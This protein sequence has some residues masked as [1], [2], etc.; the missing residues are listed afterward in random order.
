MSERGQG[1]RAKEGR[2]PPRG[3]ARP[4]SQSAH[5]TGKG[6]AKAEPYRPAPYP[7][8]IR[9]RAVQLYLEEGISAL[10]VARELG[11]SDGAVHAWAK[12][13]RRYGEA[14]LRKAPAV[15]QAGARLPAAVKE[16][17]TALKREEPRQ[18]ARRISQILRR[19]FFLK[20]SPE[21]VRRHLKATGL[22]TPKPKARKKPQRAARRFERSTPNQMWQSD[23]T[24]FPILGQ[25]AY[26][27]G[28]L[29]DY[30]RYMTGLGV[31]R[32]QP[33]AY[34]VEVY[35]GAVATYGAPKEMLT[36]N[37]RQYVSWRGRTQFQK[38][39]AKDHVHHIRSSAHHPTTLG[40]IERLWQTLKEEFLVRARFETFEEARERIG[41]WVK[42]YNHRRP[43]QG[44]EGMCPADRFFSIHQELRA[45]IERGVAAN[46]EELALRGKPLS[47]FYL[48]GRVGEKSV[49]IETQNKRMSVRVDGESVRADQPLVYELTEGGGH[50]D[51]AGSGSGAE[52]ATGSGLQRQGEGPGG[53]GPVERAAQPLGADE[54]TGGAVGDPP[55]VGE[56][57]AHGDAQRAGPQVEAGGG[58]AAE[59]AQSVG[60]VDRTDPEAGRDHRNGGGELNSE[61]Q[62]DEDSGT[63]PVRSGGK[64]SGRAGG[65]DGAQESLGAVPGD[66]SE[67]LAVLA[68]AGAGAL[69]YV[70][71]AGTAGHEGGRAGS[72]A[73]GADQAAAGSQ[74]ARAGA[75]EPGP[76][77]E[78]AQPADQG[79]LPG[80]NGLVP[81][82]FLSEEVIGVDGLRGSESAGA[83]AGDPGAPARGT[84]RDAGGAG[85]GDE[86][87]DV[88][89][90]ARPRLG[91][92][93]LGPSGSAE[94]PPSAS[95]GPREGGASRGAGNLGE[96]ALGTGGPAADP[97]GHPPDAQCHAGRVVVG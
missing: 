45:A 36:D 73:A 90:V 33:S 70:G 32:S 14:G 2:T 72:G 56:A 21:T 39:L 51:G 93:A 13:Y 46:V 81:R 60:E 80:A 86:P 58:G 9:R 91:G 1:A 74:G 22:T 18:G 29:D 42:H 43:H 87:Q 79:R 65:M 85:T 67:R 94:R 7:Y 78:V 96:G 47:P 50:E 92:D 62:R 66:G 61:E 11:I 20:A 82:G 6:Q 88:L 55:H 4:K 54:G 25:T 75:A 63:G 69:R 23:I 52:D 89:P 95:G 68:V 59:P 34:V 10:L 12:R 49:V 41:Y 97:G 27:I 3:R 17:I 40:K 84:E 37:G 5:S 44:L 38:E 8:E 30:S 77:P 57:G 83:A 53:A 64:V 71:G 35:R 19:L 48:V 24:Y 76:Q 15:R 16:K 31:Y 28:F 26:I